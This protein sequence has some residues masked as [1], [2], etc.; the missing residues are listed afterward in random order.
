MTVPASEALA[1]VHR[2][3]ILGWDPGWDGAVGK[4]RVHGALVKEQHVPSI[5][6]QTL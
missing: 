6:A 2:G 1:R 3:D 5:L 4:C